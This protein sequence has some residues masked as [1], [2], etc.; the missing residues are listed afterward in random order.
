MSIKTRF[1]NKHLG[2]RIVVTFLLVLAMTACDISPDAVGQDE[3]P[4]PL[5]STPAAE[6]IGS[7]DVLSLPDGSTLSFPRQPAGDGVVME[8]LAEGPLSLVDGCLRLRL[9]DYPDSGYLVVW[10]AAVSLQV[11]E[12][13]AITVLDS[14]GQV[15]G[16]AGETIRLGGGAMEDPAALGFWDAQIEGMPIAACPGPY[17][18]AGQTYPLESLEPEAP[19]ADIVHLGMP[20]SDFSLHFDPQVW[21][22]TAFREDRPELQALTH[23]SLSGGCRL[24]PNVP[25]G[26]GDGWTSLDGDIVLGQLSLHTKRFFENGKLRFAVYYGFLGSPMEG[27]VEVHFD[28]VGEACLEAAEELFASTEVILP[29][30]EE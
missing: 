21:E 27:A 4:L 22:V 6:P 19:P 9:A 25:V 8:A 10:P 28:F 14:A 18:I 20:W 26:L 12:D 17:W 3:T 30:P 11:S 1:A 29:Q 24:T 7:V 16:R 23:Q 13:G 15:I 5:T 2:W